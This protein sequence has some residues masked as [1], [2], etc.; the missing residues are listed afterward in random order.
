[1]LFFHQIEFIRSIFHL[2]VSLNY[3]WA[4]FS[5]FWI[6]G[7]QFESKS[8]LILKEHFFWL[9]ITAEQSVLFESAGSLFR[10]YS[11]YVSLL[12]KIRFELARSMLRLCSRNVSTVLEVCFDRARGMFWPCS[13]YVS[14]S[15]STRNPVSTIFLGRALTCAWIWNS[16]NK[17][18]TSTGVRELHLS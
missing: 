6:T 2:N 14:R 7:L 16:K 10:P 1:M 5:I 13:R 15:C 8:S 18:S 9:W 17:V 3:L 12:L 4:N 11:K